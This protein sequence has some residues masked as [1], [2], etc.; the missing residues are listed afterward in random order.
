MWG[1]DSDGEDWGF[2]GQPVAQKFA[3]GKNL[4]YQHRLLVV[5]HIYE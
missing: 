1:G 2:G 3:K 4:C 5:G